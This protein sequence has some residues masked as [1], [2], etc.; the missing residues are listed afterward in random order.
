MSYDST[1]TLDDFLKANPTNNA[2]DY[3]YFK[4]QDAVNALRAKST[5]VTGEEG[6]SGD[7]ETASYAERSA[8]SDQG[9]VG[10]ATPAAS[11]FDASRGVQVYAPGN[12]YFNLYSNGGV[13]TVAGALPVAGLTPGSAGGDNAPDSTLFTQPTQGDP[14]NPGKTIATP[15]LKQDTLGYTPANGKTIATTGETVKNP[16]TGVDVPAGAGN[17]WI[18]YTDGTVEKR[19][20]GGQ[21]GNAQDINTAGPSAQDLGIKSAVAAGATPSSGVTTTANSQA[22]QNAAVAGAI[23]NVPAAGKDVSAT[24]GVSSG[25]VGGSTYSHNADEINKMFKATFGKTATASELKY[26]QGRTDKTGAELAGAMQSTKAQGK[27]VG[28]PVTQATKPQTQ[29]ADQLMQQH[30]VTVAPNDFLTDPIGSFEKT[31]SQV[32]TDMGIPTIQT[33]IKGVMDQQAALDNAHAGEISKINANPWTSE[34][35]R[36]K[37]VDL[38]N[39]KYDAQKS[40]LTSE[41]TLYQGLYDK[42]VQQAQYVANTA[43]SQYNAQVKLEQDQLNAAADRA[44]KQQ[45]AAATLAN[46]KNNTFDSYSNGAVFNTKTGQWVIPPPDPTKSVG[47]NSVLVDTKTGA[48]VNRGQVGAPVGSSNGIATGAPGTVTSSGAL[49]PDALTMTAIN[50]L[51]TG[52]LPSFGNSKL[53]GSN[54]TAIINEASKI[55]KQYGTSDVALNKAEYEANKKALSTVTNLQANVEQYEKTALANLKIAQDLASKVDSTG[56]PIANEYLQF[57]Q[58]KIQ[59][60]ANIAAFQT[61]VKTFANEYAKIMSGSTSGA[62]ATVSSQADAE[63]LINSYMSHG[64]FDS[65]INVMTKDMANRAQAIRDTVASTQQSIS[66]IASPS[67]SDPLGLFQ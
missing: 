52:V 9:N 38:A 63:K 33:Q 10:T 7:L 3:N 49:T 58:G 66:G 19:A 43:I 12:S 44:L 16:T 53:A 57:V 64:Q 34:A 28:Q 35:L 14:N 2:N 67:A 48:V 50:Y 65:V 32:L 46:A 26:W 30:Q 24:A 41:L 22:Q 56:S 62:G 47:K 29:T 15:G 4:G 39:S 60:N 59:G 27:T 23:G 5:T 17:V 51:K 6:K 13:K 11:Y 20:I 21:P 18:T 8:L 37:Q 54:K 1:Q 31:Y 25:G 61:A 36:A 55:A 40:S 45:E 42:G